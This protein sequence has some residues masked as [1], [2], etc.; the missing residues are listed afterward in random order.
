MNRI[1]ILDRYPSIRELLAEE[2]A[3]EGYMV[4]AI[5]N[6]ELIG[7]LVGTFDPNLIILD[8]FI[9][10][11]MRWDV[12]KEIKKQHPHLR[13]LIHTAFH[14]DEDPR[15]SPADGWIVKSSIFDGLRQKT[16]EILRSIPLA[17]QPAGLAT[18]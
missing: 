12:L 18:G 13:V 8:L 6:P 14:P 16:A 2:L 5:G 3:A 11:E 9:N 7:D 10:G 4:V 15:S 17:L 1:L